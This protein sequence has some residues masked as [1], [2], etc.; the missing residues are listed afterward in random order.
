VHCSHL[1][2]SNLAES[3]HHPF[4]NDKS[5]LLDR[6]ETK[7]QKRVLMGSVLSNT[8]RVIEPVVPWLAARLVFLVAVVVAGDAREGCCSGE[9]GSLSEGSGNDMDGNEDVGDEGRFSHCGESVRVGSRVAVTAAGGTGLVDG[10]GR[11]AGTFE[12]VRL[13]LWCRPRAGSANDCYKE[14]EEIEG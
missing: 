13:S 12:L 6:E 2:I 7:D 1:S 9:W 11:F 8:A 10:A 14:W 5:M 3:K 4:M